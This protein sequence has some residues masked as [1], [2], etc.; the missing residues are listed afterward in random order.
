[1]SS[2]LTTGGFVQPTTGEG[3]YDM[4]YMM[5]LRDSDNQKW[6]CFRCARRR[7]TCP[8]YQV[9]WDGRWP[10]LEGCVCMCVCELLL[11]QKL[12][13]P[14]LCFHALLMRSIDRPIVLEWYHQ[15]H[16]ME[17]GVGVERGKKKGWVWES[18]ALNQSVMLIL[19]VVWFPRSLG[20]HG[21]I[22][23][24]LL[25]P[26]ESWVPSFIYF[27]LTCLAL[28]CHSHIGSMGI[29]VEYCLDGRK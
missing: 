4:I 23:P 12:L 22:F 26:A 17:G 18:R 5:I 3:T 6:M 21:R 10:F 13:P 11:S 24:A 20:A 25:S 9:P 2:I 29:I 14:S 15:R 27:F 7:V 19:F 28:L 1:M 8:P 16:E